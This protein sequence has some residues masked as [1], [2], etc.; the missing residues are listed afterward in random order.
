MEMSH[1]LYKEIFEL[2]S[3]I[4][5]TQQEESIIQPKKLIKAHLH[6]LIM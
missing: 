5:K 4:F 6:L 1:P 2:Q 3:T